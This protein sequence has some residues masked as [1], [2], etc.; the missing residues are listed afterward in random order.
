MPANITITIP[1]KAVLSGFSS[2]KI[3]PKIK[4]NKIAE[5]LN[6]E[7]NEISPLR[8]TKTAV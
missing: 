1:K 3:N 8:I 7:I 4:A 2:K 5:Y 6:G